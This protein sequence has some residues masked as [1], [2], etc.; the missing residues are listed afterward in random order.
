M[1]EKGNPY[2]VMVQETERKNHLELL[3][4]DGRI[5]LKLVLRK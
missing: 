5:L 4:V 3:G 1:G 2:K